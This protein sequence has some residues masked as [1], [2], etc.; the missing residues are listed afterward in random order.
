M[1]S[2]AAARMDWMDEVL[3][4]IR[5]EFSDIPDVSQITRI[6]LRL[7]LA[8]ILGGILGYQR[9]S[10]GKAAGVRTHMLV[11][12]GSALFVLVPQQ[13][14]MEIQDMSRVLQGIVAG[15][16]FLCAGAIIKNKQMEDVQGLTTAA[17][18]WMTTAIG[19]A[20]GLGRESTAVLSMLLALAILTVVPHLVRSRPNRSGAAAHA[21]DAADHAAAAA[22]AA[23][24][25]AT[26]ATSPSA[27]S[28]AAETRADRTPP[29]PPASLSAR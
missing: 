20:C 14:G 24:T 5:A 6:V 16:G 15:V 4:T 3:E 2:A 26:L 8:A 11:A 25:S 18:V 1:N 9:E 23:S 19:I 17:G 12:M 21:A 27:A 13:A 22:D 28:D 29:K 7:M 10:E